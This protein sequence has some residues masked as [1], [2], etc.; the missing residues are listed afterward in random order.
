MEATT[1]PTHAASAWHKLAEAAR[2][3]VPLVVMPGDPRLDTELTDASGET[4]DPSD[5]E[6]IEARAL[7]LVAERRGR[8]RLL[9]PLGRIARGPGDAVVVSALASLAEP[10][11]ERI[12]DALALGVD[13]GLG[14]DMTV[15]DVLERLGEAPPPSRRLVLLLPQTE[16]TPPESEPPSPL[17]RLHLALAALM[18]VEPPWQV[19]AVAPGELGDALGR[20]GVLV[21]P[22]LEALVRV[23]RAPPRSAR[24]I[25]VVAAH[26]A[27]PGLY[28]G[29]LGTHGL[30]LASPSEA[31]LEAL[32]QELPRASRLGGLTR[33]PR[34][35]P[36]HLALAKGTLEADPGVDAVWLAADDPDPWATAAQFGH[37]AKW[38]TPPVAARTVPA[39]EARE[40]ALAESMALRLMRQTTPE[41]AQ[42]LSLY[43]AGAAAAPALAASNLAGALHAAERLGYPVVLDRGDA[44]PLGDATALSAHWERIV[45]GLGERQG[46]EVL[47]P[48]WGRAP[49]AW[50]HRMVIACQ[51]PLR[52]IRYRAS[53]LPEVELDGARC[54]LPIAADL[55]ERHPELGGLL[56]ALTDV[57][58]HHPEVRSL[59][60]AVDLAGRVVLA[61]GELF[62]LPR[63]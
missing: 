26:G 56:A 54:A 17:E 44:A 25:A 49:D 37:C 7:E 6:A 24:R 52:P 27:G 48:A 23:L 55:V 59:E 21:L 29:L 47:A 51:G 45:A 39:N 41:R 32:A 15:A 57:C 18:A 34:P 31:T 53:P 4:F 1:L 61:R 40:R 33:I 28:E 10:I 35:T 8:T 43:L 16:P 30:H 12:G 5:Q 62:P 19:M 13:V 2:A 50:H 9:G 22:D 14:W 60:L 20:R 38:H 63:G 3:G 42:V 58:A 36:R 11:F 46:E